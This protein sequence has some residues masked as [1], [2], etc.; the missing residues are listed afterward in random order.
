VRPIGTIKWATSRRAIPVDDD[1]HGRHG[2][3]TAPATNSEEVGTTPTQRFTLV[4]MTL[5]NS[6]ILVDQTA[7]P[8][9]TPNAIADLGGS[10]ATGPWVMTASVLPLAALM[11][12][13]GRLGD[14]YGLRRVFVVGIVM[15]TTASAL[16]GAS[17]NVPWLIVARAV[18]GTGAALML[19]A[20][21]AIVTAVFPE[22]RR[23]RALGLLAGASAFFAAVGPVLGGLP[24]EYL[25]WRA[26]L[27]VNVPLALI[28]LGLTLRF[29]PSLESQ[30]R[31]ILDVRGTVAFAIG[32]GGLTLAIGQGQDWGWVAPDTLAA[33]CVGVL[34]LVAFVI[35]ERRAAD[36]LLR[37][38]LFRRR[39]YTASNLSQV[40]AGAIELGTGFLLPYFLLLMVGLSP[41]AAGIALIP[42]TVPIIVVA[43]LAGR[44]FDRSGGRPP[45]VVGFVVL[46]AASFAL[47]AGF[48]SRSALALIPGLVL[49][50]IGL[51]IVLTVN[52]P[53]G[54]NAVDAND[55]GQASGVIDTSEQLGGAVG[56]AVLTTIF[57][58]FYWHRIFEM[59]GNAGIHPSTDDIEAGREFVLRAEQEGFNQTT[60]PEQLIPVLR[61]FRSA[62]ITAYQL[63]FTIAG[64]LAVVG[65]VLC[66]SV[67]RRSGAAD[68]STP[69]ALPS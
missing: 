3:V 46:A 53:V 45:M 15:F 2:A 36:P 41:G 17:P 30:R 37:F 22:S 59:M 31:G 48:P 61:E 68:Q 56:I 66:W 50:G 10:L 38:A 34:S 4:A 26:V 20:T 24:T 69:P 49:Q 60:P 47:V 39:N 5:A 57:L 54:M 55:R 62:H 25:D 64:V 21:M 29:T 35:I 13:G 16:A 33:F 8:I 7:I 28:C 19:P 65:A 43:P 32:L 14:Q 23:G 12:F 6:M 1:E 44:W 51:G 40:I 42:A 18:Q 9:A 27:L 52:D 63:T 58:S 67:V 11:V